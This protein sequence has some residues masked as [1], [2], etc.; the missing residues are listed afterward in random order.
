MKPAMKQK[1]NWYSKVEPNEAAMKICKM[2]AGDVADDAAG[3][4]ASTSSVVDV[5]SK[6]RWPFC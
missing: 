6:L 4:W 5:G 3:L 2:L 1:L